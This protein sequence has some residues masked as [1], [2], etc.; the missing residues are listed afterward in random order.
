MSYSLQEVYKT[1][2]VKLFSYLSG[3]STPDK[4]YRD[5]S[6][7]K[8]SQSYYDCEW[9]VKTDPYKFEEPGSLNIFPRIIKPSYAE[10]IGNII[11][12]ERK[13]T[14]LQNQCLIQASATLQQ[15]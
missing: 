7:E 3:V 10:V 8:H 12:L 13:W 1:L 11:G 5:F 9:I 4:L 15:L 2:L 14:G 6:F